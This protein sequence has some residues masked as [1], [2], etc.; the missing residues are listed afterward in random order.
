VRRSALSVAAATLLLVGLGAGSAAGATLPVPAA[1][2]APAVTPAPAPA[3]SSGVAR[4]APLKT[5]RAS[6]TTDG[7]TWKRTAALRATPNL[8]A[9]AVATADIRVTYSA[10]FSPAARTAFQAAVDTWKTQI[11]S[12][13][14]IT[15]DAVWAP[16]DAGVLGQAGPAN[17]RRDFTGSPRAGTYYPDA[18]ANVLAGRDLDTAHPEIT[19][20]FNSTFPSWYLG[21][22]GRPGAESYDF[23][24]VVLHEL[25]HG[26]GLVGTL[27]GLSPPNWDDQGRGYW[28]LD[29]PGDAPTIFDRFIVDGAGTDALNT[30][31][32][33]QGSTA[34]GGLLRGAAGGGQWKGAAGVAAAGGSRPK[35]YS[36]ANFE[37]GS[38]VSHLSESAYPAGTANA[39][40]TP[41]IQNGE[42]LHDP[43]PIV[44]GMFADMGWTVSTT[45][46]P[47]PTPT[48]PTPCVKASGVTTDRFVAT[49]PTKRGTLAMTGGTTYELAMSGYAGVPVSSASAVLVNVE[50]AGPSTAGYVM[51]GSACG[52]TTVTAQQY[53]AGGTRAALV[54]VPLDSY[55]RMQL[56]ISSGSASVAV[57][58]VGYYKPAASS[59]GL[60][61]PLTRTRASGAVIRAGAPLDIATNGVGGLPATGV[62]AVV[63]QVTVQTPTAGGAVSVGPGGVT[64]TVAQQTYTA[65]R[66]ISQL[67]VARRSAD[68]KLR[69]AMSG[70]TAAVLVDIWGYY[71]AA[72]P[73]G[74]QVPHRIVP[75]RV[76]QAATAPDVTFTVPNLPSDARSVVLLTTVTNPT[77]N[78]F[79][80]AAAGNTTGGIPGV[81]QYYAGN[82]IGNLVIVPVGPGGTVRFKMSVGTGK[83]YAD[84]L[85]Y[86]GTS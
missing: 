68:G 79:L 38:S 9:S 25:G 47:A 84:L 17:F 71:G 58:V 55:G 57:T 14:P 13:V 26:L 76:L 80:G 3:F 15:I 49:G 10:G 32:Y 83:L 33:P 23:E 41:Y 37:P 75:T 24:S 8:Q 40:M 34:L 54:S 60:F 18:L 62:D 63:L 82:P 46:A 59:T 77:A 67:V 5:L 21:T 53:V 22:D 52:G 39:L 28:G 48:S 27:D 65:G 19:A 2:P 1:T 61:T 30:T 56:K 51:L 86:N 64:P 43:G 74:G 29:S 69:V 20:N 16:L 31:T 85:G 45:P 7:P 11:R 42:S 36:P 6:H 78:G 12:T 50:V 35:I 70:G 81:I 73:A 72:S 4:T 44:R 66:S